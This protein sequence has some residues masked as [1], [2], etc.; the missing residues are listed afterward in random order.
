LISQSRGLGDVYKRQ[1]VKWEGL[2]LKETDRIMASESAIRLR[3]LFAW[4]GFRV[5][6]QRSNISK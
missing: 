6:H 1:V 2:F 4:I 5:I 3:C